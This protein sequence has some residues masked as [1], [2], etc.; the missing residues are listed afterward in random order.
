LAAQALE[1]R[2]ANLGVRRG[3]PIGWA[4]RVGLDDGLEHQS[5]IRA[6]RAGGVL[7]AHQKVEQRP[8]RVHVR[9]GRHDAAGELLGSGK[10]GRQCTAA[11][12]GEGRGLAFAGVFFKELRDA[13]VEK[14]H[15]PVGRDEDVRWLDVAVDDQVGVR[16]GDRRADVEEETQACVHGEAP[17]VAKAVDGLAVDVLEDDIRLARGR[18]AGVEDAGDVRMGQS[19]EDR[20]L[21]PEPTLAGAADEA[22][23]Q[24]LDGNASLEA[25][26]AAARQPDG[27]HASLPDLLDERVGPDRLFCERR[28]RFG[29]GR[30]TLEESLAQ[31]LVVFREELLEVGGEFRVLRPQPLE[32]RGA[33]VRRH[34]ERPIE[35][36]L[37]G[38]PAVFPKN[39]HR[40][41]RA[42]SRGSSG[43]GRG[44]PS[45]TGAAPCAPRRRA[46]W[47]SPGK[48]VRRRTSGRRSPQATD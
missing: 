13:E 43:A 29:V 48:R 5:G 42:P 1:G 33:F 2:R 20:A 14:F 28:G 21:A 40:V 30:G 6:R 37:E 35:I 7:S 39:G 38:A 34:L 4:L 46:W 31:H 18:H 27:A 23:V 3:R 24:E 8:E 9:R 36:R 26:V 25:P 11:L 19:R 15:L 12:A 10:I 17:G 45:P 22:R 41:S 32:P 47:R 44:G 16:L